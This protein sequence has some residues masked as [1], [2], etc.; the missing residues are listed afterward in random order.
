MAT[1]AT[2]ASHPR[3]RRCSSLKYLRVFTVVAPCARVQGVRGQ[4]APPLL[5]EVQRQFRKIDL[6]AQNIA[7]PAR[8]TR[9]V[10]ER[11]MELTKLNQSMWAELMKLQANLR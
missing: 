1:R 6:Q 11:L 3:S 2:Y 9:N 4:L 8:Q 5:N 7:V 10:Q